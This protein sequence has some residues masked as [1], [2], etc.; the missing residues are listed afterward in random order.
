MSSDTPIRLISDEHTVV[1]FPREKRIMIAD[2]WKLIFS[3]ARDSTT[4]WHTVLTLSNKRYKENISSGI[5]L[6]NEGFWYTTTLVDAEIRISDGRVVCFYCQCAKDLPNLQ[7]AEI[8]EMYLQ[9]K[10][11]NNDNIPPPSVWHTMAQH[12][13]DD[14][15]ASPAPKPAK[16]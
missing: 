13:Y 10:K 9:A 7:F 1:Q 14:C 4:H 6:K 11:R 5:S 15:M 8:Q 12:F 16:H 3:A 2:S